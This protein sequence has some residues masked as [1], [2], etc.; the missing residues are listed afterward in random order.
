MTINISKNDQELQATSRPYGSRVVVPSQHLPVASQLFCEYRVHTHHMKRSFNVTSEATEPHRTRALMEATAAVVIWA[1]SFIA[2]KIGLREASP[3]TVVW[4]RFGIG[5]VILGGIGAARREL[6][7]P[8]T[9]DLG[10]FTLLGTIGI[11]IHQWLQATGLKTAMAST[12]AWLVSTSPVFIALIGRVLLQEKMTR[13][14]IVGI[15]LATA[16]VVLVVARGDWQAVFHGSFGVF[17][18]LLVALSAI[19]WAIFTVLSRH[20]LR[21]HG[22]VNMMFYVM[23]MGW[24]TASIAWSITGGLQIPDRM[25]T[26]AWGS[27]LFLGIFCSA[28]AYLLWYDALKHLPASQ[29]GSLLYLEPLVTLVIA[30]ILLGEAV[31][32]SGI[33]GGMIILLGVWLVAS[34]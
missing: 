14:R 18:D 16:G 29:A 9:R 3:F 7:F 1:A 2:T 15:V 25:S 4:L 23:L 17:G 26:E 12:T 11:T 28:I 20:G 8:S 34:A 13:K 24:V 30:A 5:A 10:S 33:T 21:R 27:I 19:T 31:T 22:V 32:V 6:S